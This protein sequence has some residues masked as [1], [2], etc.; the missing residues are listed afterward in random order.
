MSKTISKLQKAYNDHHLLR[1]WLM[2][3]GKDLLFH[4]R[5]GRSCVLAEWIKRQLVPMF[6][7]GE[8]CVG[9][10]FVDADGNACV[11]KGI[12]LKGK[13]W[14]RYLVEI[15]ARVGGYG[16]MDAQKTLE[17]LNVATE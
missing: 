14:H 10:V 2:A 15:V 13:P 8:D 9:Y 12:N 11:G 7:L 6:G 1:E 16:E 4:C 3:D 17:I 5:L